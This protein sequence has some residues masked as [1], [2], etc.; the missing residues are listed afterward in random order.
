MSYCKYIDYDSN[1][2]K[3]LLHRKYHDEAY[4]FPL[5]TDDEL[6]GRLILEIN[7]AGLSWITVLQ[8]EAGFREAF[9]NYNIKKIS[10]YDKTKIDQLL[11]NKNIIRNKTKIYSVL[12]N[13]KKVLQIQE[14]FGSFKSWLDT[15]HPKTLEEWVKLF[16]GKFKFVGKEIV[17]EFLLST[18][19]IE[20]A[21]SK[22]CHVYD[23]IAKCKPMWMSQ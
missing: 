12:Y 4:G 10:N 23:K 2:P 6:F 19:Y 3:M 21:H 14:E 9:D 22:D 15:N 5:E 20:G 17:K 16:K 11:T 18:G 13:A 1:D 8:K 7:Q